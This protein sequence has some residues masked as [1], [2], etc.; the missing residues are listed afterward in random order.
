MN[1]SKTY[2]AERQAVLAANGNRYPAL[3]LSNLDSRT[4]FNRMRDRLLPYVRA[5]NEAHLVMLYEQ[6]IVSARDAGCIMRA[7][8]G[9]DYDAYRK[10]EY[11]GEYE[12]LYFQMEREIID[13]SDGLGGNLHLARSR[14][15]M[16]VT[17][18]R[19]GIRERLLDAIDQLNHFQRTVCAFA[20]E[21]RD[22]LYVVHTHTQHAQP[23]MFGHYFLGFFD[24]VD[25]CI[26]RFRQAYEATNCSPM[27]A[28][29]I[30]TTGFPISRTRVSELLGFERVIDNAY[31]AIGNGDHYFSSA[32]AVGLCALELGRT[33]TDMLLWATEEERMIILADGYSSSSS[34]MPQKRNPIALEHMR[35][36][37]S[38]TKALGD[39]VLTGF[40]KSP[41]GDISDYEDI[42]ETMHEAF[43]LLGKNVDV[44][45]AVLATT[46]VNKELLRER[47][48]E[49]FSVVTEIADEIVRSYKIP[50]RRAHGFVSHLVRRAGDCGYNL[51]NISEPFFAEAYEAYFN[52]PF[53][54]DFEPIRQSIDPDRFVRIREVQGGTGP[55]AMQAQFDLAQE[56]MRR[57]AQWY[58][59]RMAGLRQADE[60]RMKAVAQVAAQA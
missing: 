9:L 52:E 21:H 11:T 58:D 44:F 36:S 28:A 10:M 22:T 8:E 55:R 32:S 51:K 42:E 26:L 20:E 12:D 34:I 14:N 43:T 37:L 27:G 24:V 13:K 18:S 3:A 19:L 41:Y 15:D 38:V 5:V 40:L 2:E 48:R 46:D 33:I 53:R 56:K 23:S 50:F 49:S 29:A 4:C 54:A 35:A 30:T 6:G 57:N 16:C 59:E 31:D 45:N 47:A 1:T 39:A 60:K 7:I 17:W 25:R